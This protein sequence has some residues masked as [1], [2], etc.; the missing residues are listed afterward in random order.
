MAA[1]PA[2]WFTPAPRR[3]TPHVDSRETS[4]FRPCSK[5]GGPNGRPDQRYCRECATAA[6]REFRARQATARREL[7]RVITALAGVAAGRRWAGCPVCT[8]SAAELER[9]VKIIAPLA[10]A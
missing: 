2:D 9:L 4:P 10:R 3:F 5:C 1:E 7:P 6:Q 8:E